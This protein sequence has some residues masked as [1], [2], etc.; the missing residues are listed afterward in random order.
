M[1]AALLAQELA[2]HGVTAT[3]SSAGVAAGDGQPASSNTISA[4][5]ELG[6]ELDDHRS[7]QLVR[8]D[9][10]ADHFYCMGHHHALALIDNGVPAERVTVVNADEGG[11]PDPF[12]GDLAT[13]R[14]CRDV[15]A[16][17]AERYAEELAAGA[18]R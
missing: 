2:A 4:M 1:L 6:I 11:V 7:H 12:G 3:I 8:E 5:A 15:L 18:S 13:Y 10:G 16:K 9:L 17:A 14:R